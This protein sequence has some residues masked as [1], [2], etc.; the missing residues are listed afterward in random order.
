MKCIVDHTKDIL[1]TLFFHPPQHVSRTTGVAVRQM[2][3]NDLVVTFYSVQKDGVGEVRDQ[4]TSGPVSLS[5]LSRL[6]D[7]AAEPN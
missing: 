7:A 4:R 3:V 6:S 5:F 1:L 2:V